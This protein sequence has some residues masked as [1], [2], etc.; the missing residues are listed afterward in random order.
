MKKIISVNEEYDYYNGKVV[1]FK[2]DDSI[3]IYACYH[4]RASEYG[5]FDICN[6]KSP[7]Y[8][9]YTINSIRHA[10]ECHGNIYEFD[11]FNE[12]IEKANEIFNN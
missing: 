1:A 6:D 4:Y 3:Y 8:L 10:L 12:F 9:A 7:R 5:F 2:E 11:S